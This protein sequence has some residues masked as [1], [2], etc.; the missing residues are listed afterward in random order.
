M[1][2]GKTMVSHC[3]YS[4]SYSHTSTEC[5]RAT[6]HIII[7]H[8]GEPLALCHQTAHNTIAPLL[9]LDIGENLLHM[10]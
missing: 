9:I 7:A 1:F 8:N 6:D 5:A 4:V 2:A 3:K 10:E